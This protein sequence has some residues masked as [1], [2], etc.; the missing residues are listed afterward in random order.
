MADDDDIDAFLYGAPVPQTEYTLKTEAEDDSVPARASSPSPSSSSSSS[1]HDEEEDEESSES[2]LEIVMNEQ[3]TTA[4][5]LVTHN[6]TLDLTQPGI[7][8]DGKTTIEEDLEQIEEK[9]WRKPGADPTDYFNYGFDEE[10]WRIYANK[11][12]LLRYENTTQKNKNKNNNYIQSYCS[13]QCTLH[14]Y[15]KEN[16]QRQSVYNRK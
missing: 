4:P 16:V 8:A 3:P 7:R 13:A 5:P 9:G 2:D 10:S 15:K 12:I 1:H 11:Q 14:M 6:K